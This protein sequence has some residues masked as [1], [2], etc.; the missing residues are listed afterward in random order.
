LRAAISYQWSIGPC[1]DA[2]THTHR[3]HQSPSPRFCPP[4]S[5]PLPPLA[6]A[7]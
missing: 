5:S 4:P 3:Q 6:C 1:G 7:A 2:H